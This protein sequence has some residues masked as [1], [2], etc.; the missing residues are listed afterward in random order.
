VS[1]ISIEEEDRSRSCSTP[2]SAFI[3]DMDWLCVDDILENTSRLY[4]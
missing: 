4:E 1:T 2:I 3:W